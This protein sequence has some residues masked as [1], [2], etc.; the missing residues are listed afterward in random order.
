ME[1]TRGAALPASVEDALAFAWPRFLGWDPALW[2][3]VERVRFH[4][5]E[6]DLRAIRR[7]VFIEEQGVAEAEE[8][9]GLDPACVHLLA[10]APDGTPLG[11]A[12]L[13]PGG[14]VGRMAVRAPARG[15][16][17]GSG[18]LQGAIRLAREQGLSRLTLDAQLHAIPFYARHGFRA[19]G[20]I[21]LDAGIEHR[22]MS[23][24]LT[25][26]PC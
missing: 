1:A 3:R 17:V 18:L 20:G 10:R 2:P 9:D 6:Q 26:G 4:E 24:E 12:R 25:R 16:G 23:L 13:A 19:H 5:A 15:R 22:Q 8:W 11:T 7:E 21:F 14:K